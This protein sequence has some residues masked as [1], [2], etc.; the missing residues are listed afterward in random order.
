MNPIRSYRNWRVY[1]DTVS[2]LVRLSDRQLGD[3]GIERSNIR[4]VAR[5]AAI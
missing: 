5:K 3:L 4:S 1:R 2:E